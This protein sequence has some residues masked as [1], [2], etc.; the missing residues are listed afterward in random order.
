VTIIALT[1]PSVK[2]P[3]NL[4]KAVARLGRGILVGPRP[5]IWTAPWTTPPGRHRPVAIARTSL[6]GH[7]AD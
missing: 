1:R 4:P 5:I 7:P 3:R 2:S 6:V